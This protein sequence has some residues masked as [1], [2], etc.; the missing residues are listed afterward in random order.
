MPKPDTC[1]DD[2]VVTILVVGTCAYS[3]IFASMLRRVSSVA[4]P[5]KSLNS[6]VIPEQLELLLT[7][8]NRVAAKL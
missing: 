1:A 3:L 7:N 6:L 4:H 2:A 8:L 5:Y